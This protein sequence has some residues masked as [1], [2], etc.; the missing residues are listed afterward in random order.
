MS[1]LERITQR[2]HRLGDPDDPDTP[3]ALLSVEEFFDGNDTQ[4]SI[5]CNLYP[6]KPMPEE[7]RELF[8]QI[9][10]RDNVED[11]R[12]QITAFDDPEWPF[13]D[14]VYVMTS[15]TPE[16]V[17]SWFPEDLKPDETWAGFADQAFEPYEVPAGTQPVACWWD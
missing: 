5:G 9:A 12:V 7:F 14:T 8:A 16:E 11:V 1:P 2:V 3:R 6:R 10:R 17:M 13:T 15:A 4:G